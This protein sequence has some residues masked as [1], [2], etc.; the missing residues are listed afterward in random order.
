MRIRHYF[1]VMSPFTYL[2]G[3]RLERIA[4]ARGAEIDHRPVDF[5]AIFAEVGG[6]PVH[7]R[8]RFRQEYRLQELERLS[9]A[10][11]MPL[12]LH[13]A[14]WPGDPTPAALA[15]LRA[16]YAGADVGPLSRR[17]MRGVWAEERDLSDAG[18]VKEMLEAEGIDPMLAEGDPPG[19]EA[20]AEYAKLTEA[21][22]ADGVFGAPFYVTEDGQRFWGQDRLDLLDA[23]LARTG[24]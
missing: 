6:L 19:C 10:T 7:K 12:N 23:H 21:A 17:M 11:E 13:P 24:G 22:L 4:A 3:D 14:H 16:K 5:A 1:T 18:V 9:L 20:A 15:I 8:H 2:A